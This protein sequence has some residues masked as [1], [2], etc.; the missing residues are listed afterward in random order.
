MPE[1]PR[2]RRRMFGPD[3]KRDVEDEIAF[4]IEMR[5]RERIAAGE[6]PA[7]ARAHAMRRFGDVAAAREECVT[8]TERRGRA[9]RRR[10]YMSELWQDVVYAVRSLRRRPGFAIL[11]VLTLALGIGANSAIFSVVNGVLLESLPYADADRLMVLETEYSNGESYAVSAPDF[12]SLREDNR[13]FDD[14]ASLTLRML[15]LTGRGEP[16]EVYTTVVSRELFTLLG[17]RPIVGRTF[18]DDEHLPGRTD[19]VVLTEGLARRVFGEPARALDQSLTLGGRAYTVVGV[20]GAG[21]EAPEQAEIYVPLEYDSTFSAQT[22][23][24]RRGEFLR[25]IG[26]MR[27]G[28][29]PAMVE[30]DVE[31]IGAS[32]SARFPSTNATQTFTSMPLTTLLLGDVRTPLLVLLGAVGLVLL[33]ACA[34][35]ANLLLARA[36][37]REGELAV[38]AALGAGRSRL[39]RQL[40][41]ESMVLAA[42]GAA[43]GL[44]LAWW[45]TRAL[46]AA[47]P[48]DI[49]RLDSVRINGVVVAFT[50]AIAMLTGLLFGVLPAF[51]ATGSRMMQAL[52]ES[53]RGALSSARGRAV[54]AGLVVAELALAVMLL[55]GAGLLI[56]SFIGMTHVDTGFDATNA[57]AF[58]VSLQGPHYENA[59]ARRQFFTSLEERL[60]SMPGV[61][62]VGAASGLPMTGSASLLGPFQVEGANVPAGVL[63]EMRV[64]TVTPQYFDALGTQL[65][66]GRALN[67]RDNAA[68]PLVVLV[69]RAT[70]ARWFADG[71]PVGQ[72]VL[73]GGTPREVVGVVDDV[74]QQ[75]PGLPVEPEMYIPYPQRST[76]TLR[77]VVRGRGDMASLA[78]RIRAEVHA[79]DP[80][81]PLDN[82]DPLGRV[83]ADAVARPRFYTTLL[84]LF[85][86]VALALAV[87]GIFGVMSYLV[88]QRSRE[89]SVRLALGADRSRVVA[90]IVGSAMKVAAAGL[91]AGVGGAYAVSGVLRSQLYG[92]GTT[93]PVTLV[94]VLL[95][96]AASALCASLLPAIRAARLDPGAALREG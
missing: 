87:V 91:I 95:I 31:R 14:V 65:L 85:A 88:A 51:Q 37:A 74:L 17:T 71:D 41:T 13:V 3:S 43:L 73:L 33:V 46:V 4:H 80:E 22:A 24:G 61:T 29:T 63:P 77:F 1:E 56:R 82:I 68:A 40:L 72:R 86:A 20:M 19:R 42:V 78:A 8:I 18:T 32:L 62:E 76:S 26:R 5:M 81:L 38:R 94:S 30:R 64:V 59:D 15:T 2:R 49:P 55:V 90:M 35:V 69:N 6:D 58:R 10:D 75:A 84:A 39:V 25:V 93:D 66:M 9:M 53:G 96:L 47:Q 44:L 83:V 45:G 7:T 92:V 67:E 79:L 70:I 28:V 52:R 21:S 23:L 54:R 27:E 34:N 12:M 60:R 50:A 89:I 36:T 48:A 57:V 16:V 11:A